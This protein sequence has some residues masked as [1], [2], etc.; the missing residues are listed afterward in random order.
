[1]TTKAQ[2]SWS[3]FKKIDIRTG[4]VLS[5]R[6]LPEARQPAYVLDIDFGPLGILK[7]SAQITDRYSI[8]Q[9]VGK[10]I[11]AVVNFPP[12]QIG[13][14]MSQC[15]VLGAVDPHGS[16]RLLDPGSTCPAGLPVS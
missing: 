10:S 7:S 16:V 8:E 14:L 11:C 2:I 5:A 1:M 4:T 13:K 15:L 3:D 6:L 9:V 12:K